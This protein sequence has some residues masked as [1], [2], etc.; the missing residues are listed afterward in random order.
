MRMNHT[1]A[2]LLAWLKESQDHY[3]GVI[4]Y[5]DREVLLDGKHIVGPQ[6]GTGGRPNA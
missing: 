4:C 1:T 5:D 2:K 6:G 3:L